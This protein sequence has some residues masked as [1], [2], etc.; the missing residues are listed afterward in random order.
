M[1]TSNSNSEQLYSFSE[2]AKQ[3]GVSEDEIIQKARE[4]G[5]IDENGYPTEY[6]LNEGLLEIEVIP[7][8]FSSN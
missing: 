8:G 1:K 3:L 5:L 4:T 7:M 2:I 6:A